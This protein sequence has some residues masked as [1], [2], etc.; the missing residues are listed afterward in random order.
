MMKLATVFIRWHIRDNDLQD[1][2]RLVVQVHDQQVTVARE[3]YAAE[4]NPI[5]TSLMEAAAKVFI[6]NG[7][8]K[9]DTQITEK[10]QK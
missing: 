8:L 2:V 7:L 9:S 1:C 5:M 6:P 4:W 10:W 3:D